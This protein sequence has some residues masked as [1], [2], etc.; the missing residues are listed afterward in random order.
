MTVPL[1]AM[2]LGL[3]IFFIGLSL[4]SV[5]RKEED[6]HETA[7]AIEED[8]RRELNEEELS[9]PDTE[10][11]TYSLGLLFGGE[12]LILSVLSVAALLVNGFAVKIPWYISLPVMLCYLAGVLVFNALKMYRG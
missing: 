8:T 2:G 5:Y 3:L 4:I 1:I 7:L 10:S 6:A 11:R 9:A 12:G